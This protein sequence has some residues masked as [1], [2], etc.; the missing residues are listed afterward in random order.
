MALGE[1]GPSV[2]EASSPLIPERFLFSLLSFITSLRMAASGGTRYAS[3]AARRPTT[4]LPRSSRSTTAPGPRSWL[5]RGSRLGQAWWHGL[6]A[7][8]SDAARH[9][10]HDPLIGRSPFP[11]TSPTKHPIVS[12]SLP[13]P[14]SR[15]HRRP[16][17]PGEGPMAPPSGDE[18]PLIGDPWGVWWPPSSRAVDPRAPTAPARERPRAAI[19]QRESRC[20]NVVFL[21]C[22]LQHSE[23][24]V[25][26]LLLLH[27]VL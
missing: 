19:S 24:L 2:C 25:A 11:V 27:C 6:S 7:L 17:G 1:A 21:Q 3:S 16:L 9:D 20:E 4:V 14:N 5:T 15:A 22:V 10:L 12:Y 8:R 23:N 26:R 18:A 13:L